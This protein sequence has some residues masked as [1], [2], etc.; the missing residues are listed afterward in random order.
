M[1]NLMEKFQAYISGGNC[2][3]LQEWWMR[4]KNVFTFYFIV[5]KLEE[6]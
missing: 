5:E 3:S 1:V 4:C 2:D 6:M